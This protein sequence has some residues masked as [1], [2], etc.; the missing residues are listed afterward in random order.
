M[1]Y[2]YSF[3]DNQTI[4]VDEL[5]KITSR[6]VSGG[7]A[8]QPSSVAELNGFVSDI[9]TP[10][11]VGTDD[12][13]MQVTLENKKITI[14]N[15]T[16][17]FDNGTVM[18]ITEPEVADYEEGTEINVYL[19]SDM[20]KNCIYPV[21]SKELP[22]SEENI[23]HL[24]H[25]ASDGTVTDKRKYAR[26]KCAYYY[27]SFGKTMNF[28]VSFSYE[29]ITAHTPKVIDIGTSDFSF[30]NITGYNGFNNYSRVFINVHFDKT[31]KVEKS[32]GIIWGD[33][34]QAVLADEL[35]LG[36]CNRV[37][38]PSNTPY[39]LSL[40]VTVEISDGKLIITPTEDSLAENIDATFNLVLA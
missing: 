5:N 25:I 20:S 8:R 27:S 4:G 26:G 6:F 31:G 17:F 28:P 30:L 37:Y 34:R 16:A 2:T 32:E 13:Q 21:Y 11:V 29:E 39:Y 22:E 24:A 36:Q 7:V 40:Y 35:C 10:G 9:V 3:F 23:V 15:G 14:N 33:S 38:T 1:S 18:E 19:K 12:T